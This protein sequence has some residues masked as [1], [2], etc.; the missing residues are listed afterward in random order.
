LY[1]FGWKP[2]VSHS[3]PLWEVNS[4]QNYPH[5]RENLKS[6]TSE[7]FTVSELSLDQKRS[8]CLISDYYR[9]SK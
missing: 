3:G 1:R 4:A 8:V 5:R 9:R 2:P 6:H 7:V